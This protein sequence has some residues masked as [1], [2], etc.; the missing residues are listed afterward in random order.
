MGFLLPS[1][2]PPP[3]FPSTHTF[4]TFRPGS[5]INYQ[6]LMV[7]D[8]LDKG[9][10]I[11]Q[12]GKIYGS[13]VGSDQDGKVGCVVFYFLPIY[14]ESF[15][16]CHPHPP[17][18]PSLLLPIK[19][20]YWHRAGCRQGKGVHH[21]LDSGHH[22]VMFFP[23]SGMASWGRRPHLGLKPR[24]HLYGRACH[25]QLAKQACQETKTLSRG[26]ALQVR[27]GLLF[28]SLHFLPAPVVAPEDSFQRCFS[29]GCL[30]RSE[31]L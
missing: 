26:E 13:S 31:L 9:I 15:L 19:R 6:G 1:S 17:P 29:V 27:K 30:L 11:L 3:H 21:Y 24:A 22:V 7:P 8:W 14:K 12:Y 10:I 18:L 2:H 28:L 25:E 4:P 5:E 20:M 23:L 16:P